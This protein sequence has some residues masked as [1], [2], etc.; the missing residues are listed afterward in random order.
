MPPVSGFTLGRAGLRAQGTTLRT[1]VLA[2]VTTW[3]TMAYIVVVNP[4][5][6]AS[7]GMDKGAVFV[8]TCLAA[9]I[10][11]AAMGLCSPTC[12]SRWHRA[13]G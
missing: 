8:A 9:A 11:S 13:W 12:R 2:G 3:L 4:S 6:L 5:I 10:G 7:A 1:E